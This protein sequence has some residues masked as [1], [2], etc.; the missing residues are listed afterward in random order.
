MPMIVVDDL[1][2]HYE[3]Y[4]RG[5]CIC[6]IHGAQG[7]VEGFDGMVEA[8]KKNYRVITPSL[9][10]RSGSDYMTGEVSIKHYSDHVAHLLTKLKIKKAVIGGSSM[11]GLV[12]LSFCFDHP[13]MTL[14][15]I[16]IDSGSKIPTD[17]KTVKLFQDDCEG[18]TRL[19]ASLGY[20]RKTPKS[21]IQEAL[22]YNLAVPKDTVLKDFTA[23]GKFDASDRL[24][25][26][27]VPTLI[28]RGSNDILMPKS[29]TEFL[30][31]GI[32]GSTVKI[33]QGA[34]H[35]SVV[36]KP[37]ELSEAIIQYLQKH[38]I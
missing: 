17:E 8:L 1:N 34:G 23:T 27:K 29:M 28:I 3:D 19:A 22:K 13:D 15:L 26:I 4:G 7:T 16:L 36:E 18:T 33:I 25:E 11:G 2:T 37:K 10:G 21:V 14:A 12:T 6:L 31:K 24:Q 9:P 5:T 20:S 32:S 35:S 38:G 30:R